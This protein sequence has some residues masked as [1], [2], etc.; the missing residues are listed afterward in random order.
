MEEPLKDQ[1]RDAF[2]ASIA[3]VWQVMTGIAAIGIVASLFMQNLP[4]PNLK[5]AKWQMEKASETST[6]HSLA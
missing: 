3:V 2:G 5:D 6:L 1:V 4:L